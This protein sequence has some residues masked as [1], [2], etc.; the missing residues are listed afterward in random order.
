MVKVPS[1]EVER[2]GRSRSEM[3]AEKAA[4]PVREVKATAE[5][6]ASREGRKGLRAEIESGVGSTRRVG[7]ERG[8]RPLAARRWETRPA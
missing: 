3:A 4:M 2:R 8:L 1:P 7:E 6:T 5:K